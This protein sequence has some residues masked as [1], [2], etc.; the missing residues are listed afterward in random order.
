[1]G[2]YTTAA[3]SGLLLLPSSICPSLMRLLFFFILGAVSGFVALNLE[4]VFERV[5]N[6]VV[7]WQRM[8]R[9]FAGVMVRQLIE[10]GPIE[11]GCKLLAVLLPTYY[12]QRR[13]RFR[14]HF[15]FS[16]LP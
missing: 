1:V 15:C 14:A 4:L 7:D 10:V 16:A 3:A 9:V 6:H 13:Y 8:Q 11:E 2:N 12:L 5:A